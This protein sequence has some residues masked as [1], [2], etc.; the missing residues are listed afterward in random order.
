MK[1]LYSITRTSLYKKLVKNKKG[2]EIK[3]IQYVMQGLAYCYGFD[4][5]KDKEII[6][7]EPNVSLLEPTTFTVKYEN[8]ADDTKNWIKSH[9]SFAQ[10]QIEVNQLIYSQTVPEKMRVTQ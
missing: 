9:I 5:V 4:A 3:R 6:I 10:M 1:R 7:V 8:R 2:W